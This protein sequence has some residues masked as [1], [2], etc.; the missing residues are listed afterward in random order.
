MDFYYIVI[1]FTALLGLYMAWNIGANDVA[2]SMADAVGSGA[3]SIRNAVIAAGLCE[4]AGAVLVGAHVTN[5][6]RKGIVDPSV[7]ASLPGVSPD[8]VAVMLIIGMSGALLSA[9]FW[10]NMS[11]LVGMPVSTTHS[12]VGAVAGFGIVAAG[13]HAVNWVKMGQIVSSWFI[14]PIAGG[15]LS[16]LLFV[17]ISKAILGKEKPVKAAVIHLPIIVFLLTMVVLLATIYKGLKHVIGDMPWL[18]GQNSIWISFAIAVVMAFIAWM[19]A[20]KKLA[21]RQNESLGDQ[22]EAVESSFVPLVIVSSC[23]VAFAHG[24]ND[25][26]NSVGPLAAIIHVLET[27]SIEMKVPVPIWILGLGG[28]GIVLGLATYGYKV[29]KTVGYKITEITPSRGVAADIAATATVLVCTR[30]SLPVSTTHTLVGAILGI[31]LARGLGGVNSRV[32]VSI[33]GSWLFTVPAAGVMSIVFYLLGMRFFF[34]PL[35]SLVSR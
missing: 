30:L 10:L 22:L 17:Y 28:A 8:E 12:I 2:N 7:L 16:Y 9:A 6:V 24:A 32:V 33:F 15:V 34:E 18:A 23:S 35:L 25:V 13:W 5:T 4:F 21:A 26:A 19:F 11:T 14:S 29:M 27:G 3:L 20:K 31:G 1:V